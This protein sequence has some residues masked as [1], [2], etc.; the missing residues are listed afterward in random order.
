MYMYIC[1]F[2][3]WVKTKNMLKIQLTNLYIF[4]FFFFFF[5]QGADKM[6]KGIDKQV[7][8]SKAEIIY[9]LNKVKISFKV[10]YML[11]K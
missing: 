7:S 10:H 2:L 6:L 5:V 11:I 8:I 3:K 9:I 4:F 1:D